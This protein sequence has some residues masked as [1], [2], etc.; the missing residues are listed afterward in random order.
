MMKDERAHLQLFDLI[1][2]EWT[3]PAAATQVVFNAADSV[4]AFAC[5]A[6]FSFWNDNHDVRLS[7]LTMSEPVRPP[8]TEVFTAWM[9]LREGRGSFA[10]ALIAALGEKAGCSHTVTFD[11]QALRLDGF[12]PL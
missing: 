12:A 11:R 2:R 9:A 8:L 10:D 6:V 1:A 4:V 7:S 3:L 5:A